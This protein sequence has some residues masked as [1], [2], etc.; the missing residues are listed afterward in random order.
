MKDGRST[1]CPFPTH[2]SGPDIGARL[3]RFLI[4]SFFRYGNPAVGRVLERGGIA[5]RAQ[6]RPQERGCTAS[7]TRSEPC[8]SH[9]TECRGGSGT[10]GRCDGVGNLDHSCPSS[11]AGLLSP[12]VHDSVRRRPA[13]RH[14]C[15]RVCSFGIPG[16]GT[17]RRARTSVESH[18]KLPPTKPCGAAP[19]WLVPKAFSFVNS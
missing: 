19:V 7:G 11:V 1:F 2:V 13:D 17:T 14:P 15:A 6:C 5:R 4:T 12:T 8:V 16:F 10:S 3:C 9:Q 18:E